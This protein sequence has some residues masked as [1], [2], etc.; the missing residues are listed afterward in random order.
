[1]ARN[2]R[3]G[4]SFID[5][6][7]AHFL[8]N[9]RRQSAPN[10]QGGFLAPIAETAAG[11]FRESSAKREQR[12]LAKERGALLGAA[13]QDGKINPDK[14]FA[15]ALQL[16]MRG[17]E[18]DLSAAR[19]LL[20]IGG[21]RQDMVLADKDDARADKAL[22][23][24]E[25]GQAFSQGLQSARFS[26]D[27]SMANETLSLKRA[28]FEAA[29]EAAVNAP[30]EAEKAAAKAVAVEAA[31]ENRKVKL[32]TPR[33]QNLQAAARKL[34]K[35][36]VLGQDPPTADRADFRVQA[37]SFIQGFGNLT[38]FNNEPPEAFTRQHMEN[39]QS[40]INRGE[41]IQGAIR[42]YATVIGMSPEH[43]AQLLSQPPSVDVS[44]GPPTDGAVLPSQPITIKNIRIVR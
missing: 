42:G 33:L 15:T 7:A 34:E 40:M 41:S 39:L 5:P 17:G 6:L 8:A 26:F 19:Q 1:M 35:A 11:L 2:F 10:V 37:M 25:R 3:T 32:L 29:K 27:K 16:Q 38:N 13:F 22:S 31:K 44:A 14:L 21:M 4:Q 9:A 18:D 12:E 23:L 20:Q 28:Q 43:R 24:R 30:T 36:R